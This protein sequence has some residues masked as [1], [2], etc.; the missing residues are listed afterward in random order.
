MLQFE[1]P[2]F[3]WGML[4]A[5]APLVLHFLNW[6]KLD[7]LV[8]PS[9]R[10]LERTQLPQEGRRHPK[11]II[12]M[13][14]RMLLLA[15]FMLML[16]RPCVAPRDETPAQKHN[17][18][19]VDCSASMSGWGHKDKAGTFLKERKLAGDEIIYSADTVISSAG[20]IDTT[21]QG[22][23]SDA[24]LAAAQRL[25]PGSTLTIVSD[26]RRNDWEA[27]SKCIPENV[28][29]EF[30]DCGNDA[31]SNAGITAVR[32]NP[33]ANSCIRIVVTVAN[34]G[35]KAEVRNVS[36]NAYGQVQSEK[37][38]LPP[39]GQRRV[40]F[41]F[42]AAKNKDIFGIA[43][44]EQDDYALDDRHYFA[45]YDGELPKA[46][47]IGD[48][49]A[50]YIAHAMKGAYQVNVM[51]PIEVMPE[52]FE[53]VQAVFVSG[54]YV[55]LSQVPKGIPL[56]VSGAGNPTLR[57]LRESGRLYATAGPRVSSTAAHSLGIGRINDDALRD[58]FGNEADLFLY[59][60]PQHLSLKPLAASTAVVLESLEGEP[61]LLKDGN[62]SFFA[63]PFGDFVLCTSFL[64][65]LREL[66]LPPKDFGIVRTDVGEP[67]VYQQNGKL[68]EVNVPVA[69]S[70]LERIDVQ[71]LAA[72]ITAPSTVANKE[73]FDLLPYVGAMLAIV[74]LAL[75]LLRTRLRKR[76]VC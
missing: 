31:A 24:L 69:E 34:Y 61:L 52:D 47:V 50:R 17:V 59:R 39:N 36:V 65:L 44:L 38:E 72:R 64:P 1:Y 3:L 43:S 41:V 73:H 67:G 11:D 46:L 13:L 51:E 27:V 23:H 2:M 30:R 75:L 28:R 33:L 25:T 22:R 18:C 35:D 56:V 62:C 74:T 60:I 16:A 53:D 54:D 12:V 40:P 10:F 6:R 63:F 29:L 76:G 26:F 42:N 19:I 70:R 48:K 7:V 71:E 32:C 58:L 9:I 37:A 8:F 15:L 68:V 45:L 57:K 66:T 20:H 4:A 55:D 21:K 14:L 49:E 5:L